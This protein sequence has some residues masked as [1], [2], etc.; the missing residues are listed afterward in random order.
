MITALSELL[1]FVPSL[2]FACLSAKLVYKH[3]QLERSIVFPIMVSV[4]C[5]VLFMYITDFSVHSIP[6]SCL[7]GWFLL[8]L[9]RQKRDVCDVFAPATYKWKNT[10]N[11]THSAPLRRRHTPKYESVKLNTCFLFPI[12]FSFFFISLAAIVTHSIPICGV[13]LVVFIFSAFFF[14]FWFGLKSILLIEN[15][16]WE[17]VSCG[18]A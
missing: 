7:S 6:M 16:C 3:Y 9:I 4:L 17:S 8:F 2:W 13:S 14:G 1:L 5:I 11:L 15:G 10:H 12:V 18:Y